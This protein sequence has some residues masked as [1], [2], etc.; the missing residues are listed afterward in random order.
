[1]AALEVVDLPVAVRN[2]LAAQ[3][4]SSIDTTGESHQRCTNVEEL[5]LHWL[6]GILEGEGTFLRG[7][8]SR[9][10]TPILRV[11]MTDRDVVDRVAKLFGRAVVRLRRRRP[12]HKLPY[13]TSI[14]VAPA[15]RVMYGVRALLG[16]P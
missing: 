12:H 14:K 10:G 3:N 7:A 11:S 15:T 8:P 2:R 9:P 13:S 5:E 6:V 16:E 4:S 1:M